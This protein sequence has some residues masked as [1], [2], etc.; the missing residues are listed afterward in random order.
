MILL[1]SYLNLNF[2]LFSGG[3]S[4]TAIVKILITDVNDNRPV[5]YPR[6]YNVSL[7]E[8][9]N[10]Q[11]SS[12][13][14]VAVVATDS[15]SGKYGQVTYRIVSGNDGNLFR[16][17]R[18]TGEI[19][20]TQPNLIS[21]RSQSRHKLNISATDGAGLRSNFDAEV[22]LTVTNSA[23]GPPV[24][25]RSKYKFKIREDVKRSTVVGTVKATHRR[26]GKFFKKKVF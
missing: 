16:I 3:L 1:P 24:F 20:V 5:F 10:S 12:I 14:V 6:E 2:L 17:D 15:D 9:R 18:N 4:T 23:H 22:Y 13:P 7:S 25:E 26:S 21:A 11:S 19:F 8:D